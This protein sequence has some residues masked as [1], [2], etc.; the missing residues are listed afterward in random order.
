MRRIA[1][2][3]LTA[4]LAAAP[5][6]AQDTGVDSSGGML[7]EFLEDTLSGENRNIRVTGLEGA[8]SSRA[9]I[10]RLTV[11]DDEGAWLTIE[12]AELDWN[13]LALLRGNFSVN[14]LKADLIRVDRAPNPAPPDPSL[15]APEATPFQLPEL[16]VSIQIGEI[17][18]A[19][20]ELGEALTG[21]PAALSL[22]GALT[23]A[24]GTLDSRLQA[25]RLDRPGD[26]LQMTAGFANA[27]REIT[28]DMRLSESKDGLLAAA[29]NLPGRPTV[30]FSAQ[31]AGPVSDFTADIRLATN[32]TER[33]AGQVVLAAQ[34]QEDPETPAPIAFSAD[35]GGD[36][37]PLMEPD[38][39]PFF[40]PGTRLTA[41]GQS[42]PE[43]R[44][45]LDSLAL[46]TQALNVTGALALAPGGML[47]T[48]NLRASITPPGGMAAVILPVP[49]AD[50]TL[51]ALDIIARKSEGAGW[52]VSG[53]LAGLSQPE[54]TL[55]LAEFTARG[56]LE[57]APELDLDGDITARITGLELRDAA[58]SE[59]AGRDLSLT[60]HIANTG[61]GAFEISG[62]QLD[63]TGYSA[64]GLVQFEG[65]DSGLRISGDLEAAVDDLSRYSGL[66]G[67]ELGGAAQISVA[68]FAAPLN[69]T[70]DAA[71]ALSAQDLES[72]IAQIDALIAGQTVLDLKAARGTE[73][74]RID[75][76]ALDG[77]QLSARA[78]GRLDSRT[79]ALSF[80][81]RLA[82][83]GVLVPQNP[84]PLSVK[85]DVTRQDSTLTGQVR[86]QGPHSSFAALDGSTDFDGN[87]DFT[88]DAALDQI[89]RFVPELAGRLT[90]GGRA[91]RRDGLW[92]VEADAAGPAGIEAGVR[93]TWDE[94]R[95]SADLRARGRVRLDAANFFISPNSVNG[96]AAFDLALKG[97]PGLD[98][99][100][101]TISTAGT[102]VAVPAALLRINDI[103]GTVRLGGG[104]AQV[105]ISASPAEGG[106][107]RLSGPVALAPP[108]NSQL[109]ATLNGVVLTDRL[110]YQTILSGALA[111]AGPL[112]GDGQLSGRI[113][114][115]ETNINVA[116]AGGSVSAA[117][118][119][120]IR[121]VNEGAA[122]AATRRRA[123]LTGQQG[124][125]R[126]PVI[127]LDVLIS[128]PN[129]IFARGRGLN[130]ELGGAIQLRGTA[131]RLAPSGQIS[132]IRGTFDI[133]GRR[134]D[135]SDGQ[136]TLQGN[137][138]PY[139]EF[140]STTSTAEGTAT[141]EVSGQIDAPV[142]KVTSD[143]SRPSEEALALL[144]F[145]D[146][147]QDLS[148][149]ALARLAGSVAT[150]SGRGGRTEGKVREGLGADRVDLGA[151]NSG[152]GLLGIGGYVS[153]NVYTDIN[154]NTR[155]ESELNINLDVTG[156]ITVKGT[157]DGQGETGLGVF[158]QRDY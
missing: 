18:A 107:V 53:K 2:Y 25:A 145:G 55:E 77:S 87:A 26:E 81:A 95:A 50:T 34:P 48:A 32:G 138:Q 62:L 40:G 45:R 110:S 35:L 41:R 152:A 83:L 22:D 3:I 109:Q 36:I 21:R 122:Q 112:A 94:A 91:S 151:D 71:L 150:L 8:L 121:H 13:R 14:A 66:A 147:I 51:K 19:R 5:L 10:E 126:G 56:T 85:G 132:L 98:A 88:F 136:V 117:P 54:L 153:D 135:L 60:A 7:A 49:G 100:S 46:R 1:P 116:A 114:V 90:A 59:A 39:R 58:L 142:I 139:L 24:D 102:S 137:L 67:R 157:V 52:D 29:L 80:E 158:F 57:Q 6:A 15:P 93:G 92:Q 104:S 144:L 23:L 130:A 27:T 113:D 9:T 75:R 86:L 123:G 143:P 133:L 20:I 37:S 129:R 149:L 124:R 11:S 154:V 120:P 97:K 79:G 82:D 65:L 33:L 96:T 42:G 44:L 74:I 89:Q 140:R 111:Y 70:F 141:L 101:G 125:G 106:T 47:D 64:S 69:G 31:G 156:N 43:G 115:G 127:G 28:L 84:G 16:P 76:F 119:P 146:N 17:R 118:I 68:G 148:P 78:S 99:L 105:D 155:G 103:G 108:F 63:G 30:Q 4:A 61:A 38:Y 131:A 128:A 73:G 72:G 134:L 12:G